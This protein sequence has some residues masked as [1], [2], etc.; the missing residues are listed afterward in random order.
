MGHGNSFIIL[1]KNVHPD[2]DVRDMC[3]NIENEIFAINQ[4]YVSVKL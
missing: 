1:L 4:E 2:K 3:Y